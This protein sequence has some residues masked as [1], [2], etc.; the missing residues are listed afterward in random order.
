MS[1]RTENP[2]NLSILVAQ[3]SKTFEMSNVTQEGQQRWRVL[4]NKDAK[5]PWNVLRIFFGDSIGTKIHK[6]TGRKIDGLW[7][8]STD[9]AS[10]K[11]RS[12]IQVA[13]WPCRFHD[14]DFH[15]CLG[16]CKTN[17][18]ETMFKL[19]TIPKFDYSCCILLHSGNGA[20]KMKTWRHCSCNLRY[21]VECYSSSWSVGFLQS[22]PLFPCFL[23]FSVPFRVLFF[24]PRSLALCLSLFLSLSF[25]LSVPAKGTVLS[26]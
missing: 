21:Y 17:Q 14:N 11:I 16:A 9:G 26:R 22:L 7:Q 6:Q 12:Y 24:S 4:T 20:K 1:L 3:R 5:F 10:N 25:F 2:W 8:V 23:S 15:V 13:S 18:E 19:E